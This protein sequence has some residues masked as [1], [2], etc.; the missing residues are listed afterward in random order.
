MTREAQPSTSQPGPRTLVLCDRPDVLPVWSSALATQSIQVIAQERLEKAFT[1]ALEEIPDLILIDLLAGFEA[2]LQLCRG[3][4][5]F[6][7]APILLA[8]PTYHEEQ[9]LAYY[10]AGVDECLVKPLSPAVLAAKVK[11]WL[12]RVWMVP[13]GGLEKV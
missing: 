12:G 6:S 3:L 5:S 13:V 8:L 10:Q 1:Q 7:I 4:R 9:L 2:Q 11:A